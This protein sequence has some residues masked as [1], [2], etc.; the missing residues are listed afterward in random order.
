MCVCVMFRMQ[1]ENFFSCQSL[2][3]GEKEKSTSKKIWQELAGIKCT[4][5]TQENTQNAQ[6]QVNKSR[7]DKTLKV[8]GLGL[9]LGLSQLSW[10]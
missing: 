6:N 1:L 10:G 9:G 8:V 5:D 4:F 3:A 7:P 2:L